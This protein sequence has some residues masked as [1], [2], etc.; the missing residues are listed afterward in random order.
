MGTKTFWDLFQCQF[1]LQYVGTIIVGS[2]AFIGKN[3]TVVLRDFLC[4]PEGIKEPHR[5]L[6]GKPTLR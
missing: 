2:G 3:R 6:A 4:L 5:S 1:T